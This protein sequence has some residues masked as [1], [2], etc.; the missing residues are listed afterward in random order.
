MSWVAQG[1][2]DRAEGDFMPPKDER[3][4]RNILE[5]DRYD[6]HQTRPVAVI[7]N[8]EIVYGTLTAED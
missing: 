2:G 3:V 4:D 1:I 7:T 6:I 5:V 8:G